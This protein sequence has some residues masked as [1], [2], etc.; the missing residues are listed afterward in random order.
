MFGTPPEGT[1]SVYMCCM[2]SVV[3]Y[4]S[5]HLSIFKDKKQILVL[6][7]LTWL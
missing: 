7:T 2:F 5:S 6:K 4:Y 1:L 3:M